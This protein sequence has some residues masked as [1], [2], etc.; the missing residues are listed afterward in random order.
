LKIEQREVLPQVQPSRNFT[1]K[2]VI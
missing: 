2:I 1:H